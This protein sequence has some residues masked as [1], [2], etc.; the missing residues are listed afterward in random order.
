MNACLGFRIDHEVKGSN[1]GVYGFQTP[2]TDLYAFNG[3]ALQFT[4]TP[5]QGLRDTW[6]TVRGELAKFDLFAE[7]HQFRADDGGFN[8]GRET[9]VSVAYPL[10]NNLVLKLQHANYTPGDSTLNKRDV[11]KTWLTL[12]YNY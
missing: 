3:M 7:Y 4:A 9:D 2:L 11:E 8:F 6:L 1:N 10:R 12:T 5:R